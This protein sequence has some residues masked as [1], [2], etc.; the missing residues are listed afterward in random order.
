MAKTGF[1][2]INKDHPS[3]SG[4]QSGKGIWKFLLN[5]VNLLFQS[6]YWEQQSLGNKD[7]HWDHF[8]EGII[9]DQTRQ[10]RTQISEEN[11]I[12]PLTKLTHFTGQ[13]T[14]MAAIIDFSIK[15]LN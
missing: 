2:P 1:G 12:L 8:R 10:S 9:L 4:I 14:L 3:S 5:S 11:R 13:S 15:P 7:E 6:N